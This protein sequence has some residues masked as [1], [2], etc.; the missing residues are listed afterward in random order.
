MD[1]TEI[2]LTVPLRY[3][4]QTADIANMVVPYGIYIEDYSDLEQGAREIAH[5]DLI[6][7][8]LLERDRSRAIVHVYINPEENPIEAV[9]FLGERLAASGIEYKLE[10]DSISEDD[11]ANNWKKYFKP[12]KV[13]RRLL[14]CPT[15]EEVPPDSERAVLRIDP[16]MAFGTGGH[17]TTRLVLETLERY[18]KGGETMLDVGCGSG[19][20]SVA[21]RMLGA[22][23]TVGVDIDPLAVKTAVEN[24]LLNGLNKPDYTVIQGD[25]V[26]KISGRFDVVAANIVADAIIELSASIV[27]FITRGGVYIA[28]GIIDTREEDVTRALESC[29][30]K[31]VQRD[32]RGG[33][34]VLVSRVVTQ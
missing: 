13:G 9:G 22:K 16:G 6:D 7:R 10:T 4:E 28:S 23:S 32:E 12:L 30:L 31:I 19:I 20:L 33:W 29:G 5:I 1:W 3:A 8:E 14:I 25:L 27:P 2:K 34:V 18:I 26:D 11:W 24:G 17:E 21:A 15:W